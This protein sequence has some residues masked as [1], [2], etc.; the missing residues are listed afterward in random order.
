[1]YLDNKA[2]LAQPICH[3]QQFFLSA[4]P[5]GS[6]CVR[7]SATV[8]GMRAESQSCLVV[9]ERRRQFSTRPSATLLAGPHQ[10]D[11]QLGKMGN[12]LFSVI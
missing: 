11:A 6:R 2:F 3:M 9:S 4:P 10:G 5:V 12:V 8:P 7:V 1:M